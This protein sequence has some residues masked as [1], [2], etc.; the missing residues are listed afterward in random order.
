[1][2]NGTIHTFGTLKVNGT[3]YAKPSNPVDGGNCVSYN[4]TAIS[5]EN[6]ESGKALQWIELNKSDGT[7]LLL[8]CFDF[9]E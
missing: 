5:I 7:K 8:S 4:G 1:M 9:V 3:T 2:A 6:T